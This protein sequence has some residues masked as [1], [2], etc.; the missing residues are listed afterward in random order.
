MSIGEKNGYVTIHNTT[1]SSKKHHIGQYLIIW[2]KTHEWYNSRSNGS[3]DST[4]SIAVGLW[5]DIARSAKYSKGGGKPRGSQNNH[6]IKPSNKYPK[7]S[8]HHVVKRLQKI[9]AYLE[10]PDAYM[11]SIRVPYMKYKKQDIN[12]FK[13][14]AD[15]VTLVL[16]HDSK[17]AFA[18]VNFE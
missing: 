17:T 2:D 3:L 5:N 13:T 7:L 4:N 12:I 18:L 8:L 9:K 11:V 14:C 16:N 10:K 1:Y 15:S 6:L